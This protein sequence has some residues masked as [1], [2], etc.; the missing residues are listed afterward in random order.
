MMAFKGRRFEEEG[1]A[2]TQTDSNQ[3]RLPIDKKPR[4]DARGFL[5][6]TVR[7]RRR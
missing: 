2:T 5:K 6:R 1:D 7:L 3:Y 4:A